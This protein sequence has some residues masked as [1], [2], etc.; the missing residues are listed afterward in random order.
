MDERQA[1][2]EIVNAVPLELYFILWKAMVVVFLTIMLTN[3]IKNFAMYLRLRFSDIFSK[4]T[5]IIYDGFEGIIE[6]ISMTGIF[7]RDRAG[8]TKFV[9]LSRWFMGDIRY[10][11]SLDPKLD[12]ILKVEDET[13]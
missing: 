2:L 12:R 6:E 5:V 13:E 1:I 3:I 9:P 11:N 4:R 8:V 7:I 10:P